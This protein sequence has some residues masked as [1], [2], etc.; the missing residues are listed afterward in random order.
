[1]VWLCLS[2]NSRPSP[3]FP[4]RE[5]SQNTTARDETISFRWVP[6]SN[7]FGG[8]FSTHSEPTPKLRLRVAPPCNA[9]LFEETSG[10]GSRNAMRSVAVPFWEGPAGGNDEEEAYSMD[11][12]HTKKYSARFRTLCIDAIA[13][14]GPRPTASGG[15]SPSRVSSKSE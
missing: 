11:A 14:L 5:F 2:A 8:A 7:L 10:K 6:P 12:G 13:L 3:S 9:T 1:M 4:R 15:H